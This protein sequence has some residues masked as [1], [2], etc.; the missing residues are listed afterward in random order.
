M[1][2]YSP[3]RVL[4]GEYLARFAFSPLF[5]NKKTG[6]LLP[7]VFDHVLSHGCSVQRDSVATDREL[8]VFVEERLAANNKN[9][10]RGVFVANND[11][12]RALRLEGDFRRPVCVYDTGLMKNPA[13]GEI[14]CASHVNA[15]VNGPELRGLLYEVFNTN[16]MVKPSEYRGGKLWNNLAEDLKARK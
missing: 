13:H 6:A 5:F 12:L 16:Q 15:E 1:S 4:A 7:N 9:A 14:C 8:Q 2:E 10:W 3:G 11:A